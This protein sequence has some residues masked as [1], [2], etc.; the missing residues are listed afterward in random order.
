[1]SRSSVVLPLPDGPV[2]TWNPPRR[3]AAARGRQAEH[4]GDRRRR[5]AGR[6]PSRTTATSLRRRPDAPRPTAASTAPAAA[7]PASPARRRTG[8]GR[9][10]GRRRRSATARPSAR[11]MTRSAIALDEL[12]VGDDEAGRALGPDEVAQD[13]RMVLGRRAVELARRLVGEEQRR[14][15]GERDRE[16]D[17]LLLAAG[18]LVA[19]RVARGP[20]A[21]PARAA[22]RPAVRARPR[23]TPRSASGRA[24][25]S[26]ALRYGERARR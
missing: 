10:P 11:W 3:N 23:G 18:Q 19:E 25:A 4:G 16:G 2:M 6:A 26:A 13:A 24:I 5:S 12:V 20:G 14:P 1:M 21:R 7:A 17:A 8:R 9:R 22:R 15:G